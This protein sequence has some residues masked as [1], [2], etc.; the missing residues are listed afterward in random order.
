MD[1]A[2]LV[3]E[4]GPPG[5]PGRR[6]AQTAAVSFRLRAGVGSDRGKGPQGSGSGVLESFGLSL[7]E[8]RV[9]TLGVF[10]EQSK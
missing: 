3:M 2:E 6:R 7:H 1:R 4:V 9:R 8:V 10:N 5:S